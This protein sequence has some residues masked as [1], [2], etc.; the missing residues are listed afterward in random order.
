MIDCFSSLSFKKIEYYL[1]SYSKQK[2][3]SLCSGLVSVLVKGA[4]SCGGGDTMILSS[5]ACAGTTS[6]TQ[7]LLHG[8]LPPNPSGAPSEKHQLITRSP[9][10]HQWL[11]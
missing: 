8:H 9:D 6:A 5:A 11:D 7:H 4:S 2:G 1:K 3:G 10:V